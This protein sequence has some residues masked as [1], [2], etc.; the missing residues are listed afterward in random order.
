LV[1]ICIE[2][3]DDHYLVGEGQEIE[4]KKGLSI[5]SKWNINVWNAADL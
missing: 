3:K 2:G 4:I 1:R 5:Q